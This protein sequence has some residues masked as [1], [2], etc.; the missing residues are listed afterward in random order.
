LASGKFA[1]VAVDRQGHTLAAVGPRGGRV[2]NLDEP[3]D[4]AMRLD[5]L[6]PGFVA[7]APDSNWIATSSW[8]ASGVR[9]WDGQSGKLMRTLLPETI[10][11]RVGAISPD[12]RWM[13]TST[14][15]GFAYWAVGSWEPGRTIDLEK[16]DAVVG[17]MAFTADGKMAAL[18]IGRNRV[19]LEDAATGKLFVRLQTRD[20]EHVGWMGFSPDGSQLVVASTVSMEEGILRV[21][22]LRLIRAQLKE[23]GLDWDLSPYP[24][25]NEPPHYDL[26]EVTVDL[27]SLAHASDARVHGNRAAEHVLAKEWEKAVAEYT[28]ALE[29]N[30]DDTLALNNF[31]WL[32]ATCPQVEFR[33]T[34][35]ALEHG[36]K[37]VQLALDDSACWNTLGV[38]RYRAG[39]WLA[40]QKALA[41]SEELA[42]NKYFG[43][44]AFFLAMTHWQLDDTG[45]AREWYD[46]A[47]EWM[48]K[49]ASDNDELL[50]FRAEAEELLG[51]KEK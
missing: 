45:E 33:D 18:C 2:F 11:I 41:Q 43:F 16:G 6:V 50:R 31:A 24:T 8:N 30:P 49:N 26:A 4:R 35:R 36:E 19:Q 39:D 10:P 27:G 20:A 7:V 32:L 22:D 40:A 15:D 25:A 14:H 44:N 17:Q 3:R 37:A 28:A 9:I 13:V 29:L 42:P 12:G 38:V 5:H 21:L 1:R 23:M 47:V 51:V 48:D 46:K 34:T